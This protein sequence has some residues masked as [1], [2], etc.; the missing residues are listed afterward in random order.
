MEKGYLGKG[1]RE[2]FYMRFTFA[3]TFHFHPY[4]NAA[5]RGYAAR[6]YVLS[7]EEEFHIPLYSSK[8]IKYVIF[9]KHIPHTLPSLAKMREICFSLAH[10]V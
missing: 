7:P 4:A 6:G 3:F 10:F 2:K 9:L 1:M 8:F 5:A